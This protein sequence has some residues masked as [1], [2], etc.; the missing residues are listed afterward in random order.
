MKATIVQALNR[1]E[2]EHQV[3]IILACES[4][5]RA[6]GF[7]SRDSDYD[8]RFIYVHQK[9]WYLSIA[10]KRDV[11]ELPVDAI[12]DINGWDL[13]KAL[14]LMRKS[15]S[16]LLEWLCSPIQYRVWPEVYDRLVQLA[17][18][19]FLPKTAC[20]HYLAMAKSSA[21]KLKG[22]E[23]VKL[24]TYMYAIRPVLCCQWIVDHMEHPPMRI[25][26]LLADVENDRPF[27]DTVIQLIARKKEQTERDT[28]KRLDIIETYINQKIVELENNIPDNTPQ[29]DQDLFD[30]VFRSILEGPNI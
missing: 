12:L 26:D 22:N 17:K 9:P 7:P 15:N 3:K 2:E 13:K 14:Q 30:D 1:I 23:R 19:A 5:S 16:P 6:W 18:Q 25:D 29:P 8:V 20:H 21:E 10:D 28:V 11:I 27:K 24:K 4:G